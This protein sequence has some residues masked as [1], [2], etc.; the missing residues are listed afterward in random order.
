LNYRQ[1]LDL[2]EADQGK[3]YT[4]LAVHEMFFDPSK[5]IAVVV[6]RDRQVVP[7]TGEHNFHFQLD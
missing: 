2:Q 7:E 5:K 4:A 1:N 3:R 6:D